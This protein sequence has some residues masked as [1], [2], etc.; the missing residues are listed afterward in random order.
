MKM[1]DMHMHPLHNGGMTKLH[2][3]LTQQGIKQAT[4]AALVGVNQA[5]VSKLCRGVA[6]PGLDLAVSIERV[7]GGGVPADAWVAPCEMQSINA[8]DTADADSIRQPVQT[9][10]TRGRA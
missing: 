10:N 1:L 6:R 3:Y 9:V 8:P 5:T 7:T 2:T 4:F